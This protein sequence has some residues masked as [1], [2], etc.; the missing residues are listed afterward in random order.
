MFGSKR[1]DWWTVASRFPGLD[2]GRVKDALDS[3][4]ALDKAALALEKEVRVLRT[5]ATSIRERWGLP[6]PPPP[7]DPAHPGHERSPSAPR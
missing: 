6:H 7:D 3:A 4:D 2:Q 1:L 5:Q